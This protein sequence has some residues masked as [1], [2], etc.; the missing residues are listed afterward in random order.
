MQEYDV[1]KNNLVKTGAGAQAG[2]F[3]RS[4]YGNAY[5]V[6]ADS[7][8]YFAQARQEQDGA[9]PLLTGIENSKS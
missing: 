2:K 1:A 3:F 7:T 9:H 5:L 6:N 4:A 8:G